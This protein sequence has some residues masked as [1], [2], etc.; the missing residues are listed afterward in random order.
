MTKFSPSQSESVGSERQGMG[1]VSRVHC[2]GAGHGAGH[3]VRFHTQFLTSLSV[4][5]RSISGYSCNSD[6]VLFSGL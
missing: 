5:L 2:H 1:S 6:L 3:G 4:R